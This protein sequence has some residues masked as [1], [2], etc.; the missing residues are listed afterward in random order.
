MQARKQE[1]TKQERRLHAKAEAAMGEAKKVVGIPGAPSK[2]RFSLHPLLHLTFVPPRNA[3][4][5]SMC[6]PT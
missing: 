2:L 4:L 5:R 6:H 3:T 1:L